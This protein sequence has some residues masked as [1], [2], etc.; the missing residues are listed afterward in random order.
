VAGHHLFFQYLE[1][2]IR[3]GLGV[4]FNPGDTLTNGTEN[5]LSGLLYSSGNQII[6]KETHK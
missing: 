2:N 1:S 5:V 6:T 3:L 4:R